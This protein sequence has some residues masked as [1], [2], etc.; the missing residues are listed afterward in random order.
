MGNAQN[1]CPR[2]GRKHSPY[3]AYYIQKGWHDLERGA[4][5]ESRAAFTEAMRVTPSNDKSQLANYIAYLT[6]QAQARR[7]A[8]PVAPVQAPQPAAPRPAAVKPPASSGAPVVAAAA[9]AA[10]APQL[11]PA[12]Q[13]ATAPPRAQAAA[14]SAP[15]PRAEPAGSAEPTARRG[16]FFDFNEK[17]GN[18]VHVM[19]DAKRRQMEYVRSRGQRLWIVPLLL[20]AGL[21]FVYLDALLGYNFLTFSLVALV[22]WGAAV[23]ALVRLMRD[24][25]LEFKTD[26]DAKPRAPNSG[27]GIVFAVVFVGIWVVVIG[28][29]LVTVLSLI[30]PALIATAIVFVAVIVS[31]ILL[32]R[33]QPSNKQFG[34]KFDEARLIFE[35][36]KDDI[37]PKRTL[38]GWLDLTGP[39]QSKLV[40]QNTS[41]SGMPIN[42]YRDEWLKMKV[43]LYDGNVMRVTALERIKARM[44][45]WKRNARG[46]TKWK[47]GKA[48]SRNELRVA[49]TV[50]REAYAVLPLRSS[51][52]GNVLVDVQ[53]A[54]DERIVLSALAD[55]AMG[56]QDILQ[57]LRFAYDH[58]KPRQATAA[59]G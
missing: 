52:V 15:V 45:R 33:S 21:P 49:L 8:A 18:I 48:L 40:R 16:L 20:L 31:V 46:K 51:Q 37:S 36:I 54:S 26:L 1:A 34:R 2:C 22:L 7:Q 43:V 28:G 9:G 35:T 44:G 32:M 38:M 3:A 6:Q 30:S 11:K 56:A 25:S 19:D 59:G 27:C 47:A 4:E 42:Y 5:G 17:P 14:A 50:N 23:A 24:R 12:V 13:P 58:L 57:V 29:M 41:S 10:I 55:T 53:E 39:Q